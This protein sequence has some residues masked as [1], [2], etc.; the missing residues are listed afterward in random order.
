MRKDAT[1][2]KVG[3]FRRICG[4]VGDRLRT[5]QRLGLIRKQV[6]SAPRSTAEALR[7]SGVL[8]MPSGG[9]DRFTGGWA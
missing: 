7:D 8:E 2:D 5:R 4:A 3:L 1:K 6:N 9:R